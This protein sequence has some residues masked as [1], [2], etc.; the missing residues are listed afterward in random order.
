M[1][2]RF[3]FLSALFIHLIG[4]TD[5][6][7]NKLIDDP[8]V[9]SVFSD[10]EIKSLTTVLLFFRD[11]VKSSSDL[12]AENFHD[13]FH[14]YLDQ[15]GSK[16]KVVSDVYRNLNFD[17]EKK[18][19]VISGLRMSGLFDEL[20]FDDTLYYDIERNRYTH[21]QTDSI[22]GTYISA[23][24]NGKYHQ[25]LDEWS[26]TD[27]TLI[28]YSESFSLAGDISPSFIHRMIKQYEQFDLS[29][30]RMQLFY[31]LTFIML[32]EPLVVAK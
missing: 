21:N 27:S 3:L 26:K 14:N 13:E 9:T 29:S 31:A 25:L 28:E 16:T 15:I 12:E 6:S 18:N 22:I 24:R 23:K 10:D 5:V 2:T 1:K 30:E 8:L 17:D 11:A 32:N 4:C 7:N 20:Y 19:L